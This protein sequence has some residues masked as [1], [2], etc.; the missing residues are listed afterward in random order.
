MSST[1]S[2]A[3]PKTIECKQC[4]EELTVQEAKD[5]L[6]VCP[7]CQ[8]HFRMGAWARI[9][10]IAD[11]GSF[12]ESHANLQPGNPLNFTVGGESYEQRIERAR[13][14]SRLSEA[15]VTGFAAIEETPVA[16]GAMDSSF[17]MASMGSALG[18]RLSRLA[19]DAVEKRVPLVIF[20]ASGGARMQEGTVALMQ[21]AKTADAIRRVKEAGLPYISVLSD[22]TSG[23]VFASFATIGDIVL[24]EP[25][26]YIGFAGTRL[27]EGALGVKL[28]EGFQKAEYQFKNGFIDEIVPRGEMR[29]Y[30]AKLVRYLSPVTASQAS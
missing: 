2:D 11:P 6:M 7:H 23:G 3:K 14:Q 10:S 13:K 24:A 17:I 4:H 26:A 8:R 29:A 25:E 1:K 9:K 16:L 27:I 22:P 19:N 28:P 21:M 30:L 12:E 5:N 20:A 18:E 15:L